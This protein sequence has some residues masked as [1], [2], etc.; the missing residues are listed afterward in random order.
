[1]TTFIGDNL[2]ALRKSKGLTLKELGSKIN[3]T[4]QAISQYERGIRVPEK[5]IL[6]KIYKAL[7]TTFN[8]EI[9]KN[10]IFINLITLFENLYK[11]QGIKAP[12]GKFPNLDLLLFSS[13]KDTLASFFDYTQSQIL[14]SSTSLLNDLINL[15]ESY[16]K[17]DKLSPNSTDYDTILKQI[18]T[19]SIDINT[20]I[21]DCT[22]TPKGKKL[23]LTLSLIDD[24]D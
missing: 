11:I 9:H 8:K 23:K 24:E 14:L 16:I 19:L 17:I 15:K 3:L 13:K 10:I 2:K 21:N 22:P 4:P 18:E 12:K 20:L 1:M 7:G 5:E 6:K